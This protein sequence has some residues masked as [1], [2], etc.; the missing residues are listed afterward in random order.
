V[1]I[2]GVDGVVADIFDYLLQTEAP[3]EQP[4]ALRLED[5]EA[6]RVAREKIREA[7][8]WGMMTVAHGMGVYRHILKNPWE[9]AGY[10]PELYNKRQREQRARR[11]ARI[12]EEAYQKQVRE[13]YQ[14]RKAREKALR[15]QLKGAAS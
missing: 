11:R 15:A 8:A 6:D 5:A 12:G 7:D 4:T 2:T 9:K 10:D 3:V 1:N 14:R 13:R